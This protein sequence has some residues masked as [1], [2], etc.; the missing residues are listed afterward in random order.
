MP[1]ELTRVRPQKSSPGR[2]KRLLA[3]LGI[4]AA[5]LS[6]SLLVPAAAS[7]APLDTNCSYAVSGGK[8]PTSTCWIDFSGFDGAQASSAAGQ[9][10]TMMLGDY[11]VT[12]NV[13]QRPVPG[14]TAR[15]VVASPTVS[16]F[17]S[18]GYYSGITGKPLLYSQ[19]GLP[20]GAVDIEI[21]NVAIKL[22]TTPVTGYSLVSASAET[23][24][25]P[26]GFF[27]ESIAWTSDVPLN[28]IDHAYEFTTGGGCPLPPAGN[29]NTTV[30]CTGA[31][32]GTTSA[33][34]VIM[35]G[36]SATRISGAVHM[37]TGGEREAVAFG[38]QTARATVTKQVASRVDPTDSFD[39]SITSPEGVALA[40][41]S[42]GT[43]ATATTGR[44]TVIPS[45]N[46]ALADTTT[47]G[48]RSALSYYTANWSC[49]N[50]T[51]GS[52]TVLP[53]GSNPAQSL[54][55]AVGDDVSCVV[56]N[57]ALPATLSL[58]KAVN[59][60]TSVLGDTATYAF[61]VTN[62]G[63]IPLDSLAIEETNFSGSGTLSA[64]TCPTT[65]LA[66]GAST[67]C[68]A[69]YTVTQA[70]VDAARV[71]NTARATAH[72][73][74]TD[75]VVTSN[76]SSAEFAAVGTGALTVTKAVSAT[77]VRAGDS[78]TYTL[79]ARN[80]GGLTLHGVTL[81]DHN[82]TGTGALGIL[83]CDR[84]Q[85]AT[86]APGQSLTCTTAYTVTARDT[87]T[88]TNSAIGSAL[89]PSGSTLSGTDAAK[90]TVRAAGSPAAPGPSGTPSA[91]SAGPITAGGGDTHL[92]YT[93]GDYTGSIIAGVAGVIMLIA[94]AGLLARAQRNARRTSGA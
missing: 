82:F 87:D 4:A 65:T 34:G 55:L 14:K 35:A 92:A 11:T 84:V 36:A 44:E 7:A 39:V 1:A 74:G 6:G 47:S 43:A 69:T 18:G 41:A 85:P 49:T 8:Y 67:N 73:A 2:L 62:T 76:D 10:M 27:Q 15:N 20:N 59:I 54:N 50:A 83:I 45:G 51:T 33:H 48:T 91:P 40:N 78:L 12:F 61:T 13:T 71:T 31:P 17:G 79:K 89:D 60:A 77:S 19:T 58:S 68:Q 80:S 86:L 88:I 3:A 63:Q 57:T 64:V 66:P 46:L 81:E 38:I 23:L 52:T 28:M 37:N 70:D 24:D 22:G 75:T 9:D 16:A 93:G 42:T 5:A 25:G 30:S 53:S 94:A 56:T 90:V 26:T 32:A 72:P 21:R 29:G